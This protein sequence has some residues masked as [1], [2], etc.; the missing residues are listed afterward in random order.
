MVLTG[1]VDAGAY[2]RKLKQRLKKER[3][4]VVTKCHKLK[5]MAKD[6]KYYA[7]D[8]A[9][10]NN[11]FRDVTKMI[12]MLKEASKNIFDKCM[13]SGGSFIFFFAHNILVVHFTV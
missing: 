7:S 5:F 10:T 9:D 1:S 12:L 4:Q 13:M 11:Y 2:W 3:S 8:S 6:G